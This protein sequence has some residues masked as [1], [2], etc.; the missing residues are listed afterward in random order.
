MASKPLSKRRRIP[1]NMN[2]TPI[3]ANPA[4]ISGK[5]EMY[6][7]QHTKREVITK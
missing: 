6:F 1:K 3:P 7:N 2:A 4:P 5:K